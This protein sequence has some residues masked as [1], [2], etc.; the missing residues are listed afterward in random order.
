MQLVAVAEES[1]RVITQ[2][3]AAAEQRMRSPPINVMVTAGCLFAVGLSVVLSDTSL[4]G[5]ITPGRAVALIGAW[6]LIFETANFTFWWLGPSHGVARAASMLDEMGRSAGLMAMLSLSG[7]AALIFYIAS[8]VRGFAWHPVPVREVWRGVAASFISHAGVAVVCLQMGHAENAALVM[9]AFS[10]FAIG[11]A[12]TGYSLARSV[13]ARVERDVLERELLRLEVSTV[14]DRIARELHDGI[15]ADVMALL[16]QL[17]RSAQN[18]SNAAL[19]A[20]Q[21]Q[22]VL[23]DLRTVVWSLR[24]GGTLSEMGKLVDATCR[25]LCPK[26]YKRTTSPELALRPVGGETSLSVLHI[27]R[28]LVGAAA[29]RGGLTRV[30]V[31]L[32]IE[33]DSISLVVEADGEKSSEPNSFW[34]QAREAIDETAGTLEISEDG[35]RARATVPLTSRGVHSG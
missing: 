6:W 28:A 32:G 27:A 2:I 13:R 30:N 23:D 4:L 3:A 24:S 5:L 19:L 35:S 34:V 29:G 14:R 7:S 15:G 17:R 1:E 21:A 20:G 8:L 16:L 11:R 33:G 10:A 12:M 9:L 31:E 22:E 25:R 18:E 26:A